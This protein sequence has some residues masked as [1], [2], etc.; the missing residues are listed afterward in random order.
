MCMV[1][2]ELKIIMTGMDNYL[3]FSLIN[4]KNSRPKSKRGALW[5]S[6]YCSNNNII[7]Y[8]YY[9]Y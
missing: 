3:F 8:N 7:D 4:V 9:K 6:K 1:I 5:G 2:F